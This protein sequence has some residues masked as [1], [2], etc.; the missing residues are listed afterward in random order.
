MTFG[1]NSKTNDEKISAGEQENES[2]FKKL[3]LEFDM[4]PTE[5]PHSHDLNF[6]TT[7]EDLAF[8]FLLEHQHDL[9]SFS[10]YQLARYVGHLE[11]Q[12]ERDVIPIAYFPNAD[13]PALPML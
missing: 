2:H 1:A 4:T 6:K 7:Y 9:Y 3:N 13:E 12:Y 5:K 11:E 8:T 10:I